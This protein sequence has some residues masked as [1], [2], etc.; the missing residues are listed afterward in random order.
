MAHK[1][2]FS[3]FLA[4]RPNTLHFAA[5]SHHY[6]PDVTFAAQQQAWLDAATHADDKWS[7]ILGDVLGEVRARV[8]RILALPD[9]HTLAFAPNTHELVVRLFSCLD[10]TRP[11]SVLTTDGEFHSFRRQLSRWQQAGHVAVERVA[12]EPF[13]SFADRFITAASSRRHDVVFVSQVFFNS[14]FVFDAWRRLSQ[15]IDDPKTFVVID[16]YHGFHARPTS[17]RDVADRVFYLAGGYKYAMAGEGACFLHCPPGYGER[18]VNTGW[19]AGFG[20][21][22]TARGDDVVYAPG[23]DRFWGSTFDASGLY[24]MRASLRRWH[25]LG[26]DV[27]AIH[28]HVVGLQRRFL[29]AVERGQAGPLRIDELVPGAEYRERGHFLTFRRRDAS[30][31]HEALRSR[32]VATDYRDDRLRFGFALYHDASDVDDVI[33]R[34]ASIE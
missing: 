21:L 20:A 28:E 25:E 10:S 9:P 24:R 6:W 5:H 19:F 29:A 16:G 1:H 34:L 27:A 15:A 2:E 17:L 23:G 30:R 14:G 18:P 3:R 8:A 12:V 31:L 22:E 4:A 13:D 26:V 32:D 7:T 33:E 11:V